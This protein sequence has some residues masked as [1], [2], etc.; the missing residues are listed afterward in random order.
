MVT[1]WGDP[2]R[3]FD[4]AVG[5]RATWL[6]QAPPCGLVV[7]AYP[8]T[9]QRNERAFALSKVDALFESPPVPQR[10]LGSSRGPITSDRSVAG[11]RP[12]S[13]SF[14]RPVVLCGTADWLRSDCPSLD[15]LPGAKLQSPRLS[16]PTHSSA[17]YCRLGCAPGSAALRRPQL[18]STGLEPWRTAGFLR[19][20]PARLQTARLALSAPLYGARG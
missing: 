19:L 17:W 15:S 10:L 11:W 9:P 7:R 4:T 3:F 14:P 8:T 2:R 20:D 1:R 6:A 12:L 13:G 18:P 16:P 5:A